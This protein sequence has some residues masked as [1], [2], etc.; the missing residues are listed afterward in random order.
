VRADRTGWR[1]GVGAVALLALAGCTVV[2]HTGPPMMSGASARVAAC[3]GP[4]TL[5][6]TRVDVRLMDMGA[7]MMARSGTASLGEH[8]MLRAAPAVVRAGQITLVATNVGVRTH[9]LVVLP[10]A[11]GQAVGAR[12]PGADA[13]VDESGNLG[14]A[15]SSC[16]SGAGEGIAAGS[17]SWVTLT[18]APGRYELV[19]NLANHYADGMRTELEVVA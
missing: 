6:G 19:C 4:A 17:S 7:G 11:N 1:L 18:L 15:S 10:L 12:A 8:M 3:T 2:A 14:E 5:P 9:E 16:A 13:K